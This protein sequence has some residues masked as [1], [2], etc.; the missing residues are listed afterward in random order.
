[1][2]LMVVMAIISILFATLTFGLT[3]AEK[4]LQDKTQ[5]HAQIISQMAYGHFEAIDPPSPHSG[6]KI[7]C[8]LP[9]Q[10]DRKIARPEKPAEK[11][12][13]ANSAASFGSKLAANVR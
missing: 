2:E 6:L 5:S 1:M 8:R 4:H 12:R 11:P 7:P 10:A 3:S 9:D 13:G